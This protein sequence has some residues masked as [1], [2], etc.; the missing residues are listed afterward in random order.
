M[1]AELE[2]QAN[3]KPR[4]KRFKGASWPILL[5]EFVCWICL[6]Y[7]RELDRRL[8]GVTSVSELSKYKWSCS[9]L[10]SLVRLHD[11][12]IPGSS[13][14]RIQAPGHRAA[15]A[16]MDTHTNT[17]TGLSAITLHHSAADDSVE[18]SPWGVL[19]SATLLC[20]A[21][22]LK[23]IIRIHQAKLQCLLY[24]LLSETFSSPEMQ[25]S[26]CPRPSCTL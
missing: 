23:S 26:S 16:D 6:E 19:L 1:W 17:N 22:N 18:K 25:P 14:Q 15:N 24:S 12:F 3:S 20:P 10:Y 4:K 11:L 7:Q 5:N 9:Y 2:I 13:N 8:T 21:K